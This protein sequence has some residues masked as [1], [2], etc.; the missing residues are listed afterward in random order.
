M[1]HA[2]W[3]RS[4]V[5]QA[6][7]QSLSVKPTAHSRFFFTEQIAR[8][9]LAPFLVTRRHQWAVVIESGSKAA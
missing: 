6:T 3:L 2:R 4:Q 7:S 9:T 8:T 1:R 5:L